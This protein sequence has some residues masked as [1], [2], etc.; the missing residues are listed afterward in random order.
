[1][2]Q[3]LIIL[4]KI[5]QAEMLALIMEK[6]LTLLGLRETSE[7]PFRIVPSRVKAHTEFLQV[8]SDRMLPLTAEVLVTGRDPDWF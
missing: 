1:M 2:I 6:A 3:T 4:F 7:L 5:R 8:V